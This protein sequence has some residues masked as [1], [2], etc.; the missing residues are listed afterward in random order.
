MKYRKLGRT[1][2]EVGIIGLGAEYLES[3]EVGTVA[4]VVDE[5]M[6]SGVN[7]ID[8]F[9]ASP[10]VRDNFGQVLKGRRQRVM[11]A[12]H[13]GPV[14]RDGQYSRSRDNAE[15]ERF[16]EDLLTRL[17]TDYIDVLMLHFVDRPEDY[18]VVFDPDGLLGVARRLQ[19]EGKAR[20]IGMSSHNVPTSLRAVNSGCIDVLMFPVNP[21]F[22]IMPDEMT[23]GISLREILY[24]QSP[25]EGKKGN[26]PRL[27]LYHACAAQG[28]AVVAMKPYA[29]G[30]LFRENPS[31]ITLTPVQCLHYALSQPAV[32]TAVPGC[33]SAGEMRA[34]LAY[35]E[36]GE[37]EKDYSAINLN[38]IWKLQGS[39]MYCNHCL[40]CPVGI[41]IGMVTRLADTAGI[42]MNDEI[43]ASYE[44]LTARASDCTECAECMARCPFGV[45]VIANMDRAVKIFG[46]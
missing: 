12:G 36:A 27:Q 32:C 38:T 26:S 45:E 7:Y 2:V 23:A 11:V 34:A 20:F 8:L 15:C 31:A 40:P 17:G 18:P 10:G 5:A 13:L 3:A 24:H 19:R 4:S 21:A 14:L 42:A 33:K 41:D 44:A 46:K 30:V 29:S 16:Y 6:D 39:C 28:V 22:D 37:E 25:E 35:L 9:M 1:G 43:V